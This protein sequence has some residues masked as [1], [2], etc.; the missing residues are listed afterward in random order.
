M[1]SSD[2]CVAVLIRDPV[3][4]LSPVIG[5]G[6]IDIEPLP[7]LLKTLA[8]ALPLDP[9]REEGELVGS[10]P[11]ASGDFRLSGG[12]TC[13][14]DCLTSLRVEIDPVERDLEGLVKALPIT[15]HQGRK[16]SSSRCSDSVKAR[17]TPD[18]VGSARKR[19]S[20]RQETAIKDGR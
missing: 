10:G 6:G 7:N 12:E 20:N 13:F 18:A 4:E 14:G 3:D 16:A 19:S 15:L 5:R 2:E 1:W 9:P 11:N 8:T 17:P